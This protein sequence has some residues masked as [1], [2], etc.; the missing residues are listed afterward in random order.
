MPWK[1][2]LGWQNYARASFTGERQA[3]IPNAK[4]L[5]Q[6]EELTEGKK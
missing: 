6:N 5:P 3:A 4:K 2:S 1:K